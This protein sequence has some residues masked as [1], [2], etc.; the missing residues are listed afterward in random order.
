MTL[1]NVTAES[2]LEAIIIE[3][4]T[5]EQL[6]CEDSRL[7]VGTKNVLKRGQKIQDVAGKNLIR[8]VGEL[9]MMLHQRQQWISETTV[10]AITCLPN[11][12]VKPVQ[13]M[14]FRGDQSGELTSELILASV[15]SVSISS[16]ALL[17]IA[18]Q[19]SR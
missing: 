12:L 16:S 6:I 3:L 13:V 17:E 19:N 14:Y 5:P 11:P 8:L 4:Q 15:S 2:L 18:R 7:G 1:E 9:S 10:R